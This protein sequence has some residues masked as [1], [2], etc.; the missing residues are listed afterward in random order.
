MTDL[1]LTADVRLPRI[2][3]AEVIEG[4]QSVGIFVREANGTISAIRVSVDQL[5]D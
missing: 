5:A 1:W 3:A 4:G 2:E